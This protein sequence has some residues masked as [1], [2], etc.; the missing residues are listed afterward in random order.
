MRALLLRP[1]AASM[2]ATSLPRCA[3]ATMA[4][5]PASIKL[6]Y[7]DIPFWR[8]EVVRLGLFIGD[9]PFEDIRDKK[10]DELIAAGLATFGAVPVMEVDGKVL[11]QTQ[12][13]AAYA[14]KVAG[15]H[16]DDAW[17]EAKVDECINGCTDVT[18]TLG[19][20]FR[21]PDDE[22][23]AKRKEMCEEG[24]RL[25]MHLGGLEKICAAN[26]ANGYAVGSSVTV[27]DL[28]I[29]RLC[30]WLSSGVIDGLEKDYIATTFPAL[31]KLVETT[32]S[33]PK[34]VEWKAM[35]PKFYAEE[36]GGGK[37]A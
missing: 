12:A 25:R 9:V 14:G 20:T 13:M 33:H 2:L 4:T 23:V 1:I 22:K 7:G 3:A 30:G 28:A 31:Q 37:L 17:L 36:Y 19:M 21:L 8:A 29:W 16:P 35:Y 18:S 26:G 10:R 34:V 27:A 32:G 6:Y 24:G 5:C 11:S 15:I